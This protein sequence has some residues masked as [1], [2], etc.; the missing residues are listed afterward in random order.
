MNF[1]RKKVTAFLMT[2]VLSS[3]LILQAAGISQAA[4]GSQATVKMQSTVNAQAAGQVGVVGTTLSKD[5]DTANRMSATSSK[6]E[7]V[8]DDEMIQGMLDDAEYIEGEAVAVVKCG[9]SYASQRTL[10]IVDSSTVGLTIAG[11][12]ESSD[13]IKKMAEKATAGLS[14]ST[15]TKLLIK[16]ICDPSR[17][18]KQILEDLYKDPDVI[19]AEPN[20]KLDEKTAVAET[21]PATKT[22]SAAETTREIEP[23][24]KQ[25]ATQKKTETKATISTQKATSATDSSYNPASVGDLSRYQWYISSE[26]TEQVK[27]TDAGQGGGK[28]LNIPG[29]NKTEDNSSGTIAIM[30]T[31]LDV[32]HPDLR[33]SLFTFS[34]EQQERFGCGPHGI[35]MEPAMASIPEDVN[36]KDVQDNNNHGTHLAGIVAG[37]WNGYGVSGIA[38]GAKIFSVKVYTND[39]AGQD[40]TDII[41]GFEWLTQVAKEVNLKAVNVSLGSLKSQLVHT[42]MV[43]KLGAQGANVV[44]ASGNMSLD[45]DEKIDMGG[46][47]NSPY[48]I[49]VNASD[50]DGKKAHFSCYGRMSTDVMVPGVQ[51]M[52]TIPT[53]LRQYSSENELIKYVD[54]TRVFPENTDPSHLA[55]GRIERFADA[56]GVLMYDVCPVNTDGTANSKAKQV[57]TQ[58]K[59][60]GLGVDDETSWQL[61]WKDMVEGDEGHYMID[62]YSVGRNFWMAIPAEDGKSADWLSYAATVNDKSHITSGISGVMLAHT[63]KSGAVVPLQ[64][65]MGVDLGLSNTELKDNPSMIRGMVSTATTGISSVSWSP[66]SMNLK[67]FVEEL[68]YVNSLPKKE[69][70][71]LLMNGSPGTADGL[72]IWEHDGKKYILVQYAA[73]LTEEGEA[74]GPDTMLYL[75]NIAVA[76]SEAA[77]GAY[78]YM[79]GTSMSAPSV[80]A[81][82]AVIAKDEPESS[83]LTDE[84]LQAEALERAAKLMAM[85]DYSDEYK[86]LCSTGGM[87]N[88]NSQSAFLE[89]APLLTRAVETDGTLTIDGFFFSDSGKLYIDDVETPATQ[90]T[91][92]QITADVSALSA[93]SHYAMAVNSDGVRR[94]IVFSV[95]KDLLF[96]KE[97]ALPIR[98]PA[99]V[100]DITDMM[101]GDM[102]SDGKYI[103]AMS[104]DVNNLS[105]ALWRYDIKGDSW[106]RCADLPSHILGDT[107]E[108]NGMVIQGGKLYIYTFRKG[109]DSRAGE[110]WCYN[111]SGDK[112]SRAFKK[113]LPQM[114]QIFAINEQVFLIRGRKLYKLNVKNGKMKKLKTKAPFFEVV[115]EMHIAV[116]GN[117]VYMY[118]Y[119]YDEE[120]NREYH[121]YRY[122]YKKKKNKFATENLTSQV[123]KAFGK[124]I[125][126]GAM[127]GTPSGA[128]IIGMRNSAGNDTFM[129]K[130]GK[131]TIKPMS[132]IAC[133]HEIFSPMAVY[134]GDRLY[135]MGVNDTEPDS[136]FFRSTK[137]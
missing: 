31:G 58:A 24:T 7:K 74:F 99:F 61:R 2:C 19:S 117:K 71:K 55:N 111:I 125:G 101:S 12:T 87:V 44:Y 134:V 15:N 38:K 116:S 83:T 69:I 105:R 3:S 130:N 92:R 76:D 45:L 33:D 66:C 103:F 51:M 65:D 136:L 57:G 104:A 137:L 100:T 59:G 18:T 80:A 63:D 17:T 48:V 43:N 8:T 13:T 114:A 52:S 39:G 41:R 122:T 28:S 16:H 112:W 37:T 34:E 22:E 56:P 81:T 4:V 102:V 72:Y 115:P 79:S 49:T 40:S 97:H 42:I 62:M 77:T 23:A 64:V 109:L 91:D 47:N 93:G 46:Q 53:V 50:P 128:A 121:L 9:S 73:I 1:N 98:D 107:T 94:Q 110:L 131:K 21:E 88:L 135:V 70:D 32:N 106:K 6:S 60:A 14:K 119:A 85:V 36:R 67:A 5:A 25:A 75:D 126:E 90:W 27:T 78:M 129:M 108:L 120:F 132:K 10:S 20:Y 26:G 30:D 118:G 124:D 127:V 84:Q 123:R 133:Y 54:N 95:T 82:L 35:N 68:K 86:E 11:T 29:W 96:E 89:K 113:K